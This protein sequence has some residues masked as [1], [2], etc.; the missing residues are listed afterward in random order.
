M[1][2]R[3]KLLMQGS[4]TKVDGTISAFK[5]LLS[6]A[7][8]NQLVTSEFKEEL[9][10]ILLIYSKT[11]GLEAYTDLVDRH[12]GSPL[13]IAVQN[14]VF[15][16]QVV[17]IVPPKVEPPVMAVEKAPA[18]TLDDKVGRDVWMSAHRILDMDAKFKE[19]KALLLKVI[20]NFKTLQE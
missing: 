17:Q 20:P 13:P 6:P 2:E 16:A 4:L 11:V 18:V 7:E 8:M 19:M 1:Y 15:S 3:I 10:R 12:R 5:D 9:S 14:T